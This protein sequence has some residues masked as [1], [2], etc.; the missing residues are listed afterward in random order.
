MSDLDS[1]LVVISGPS[2]TGKD[3]ITQKLLERDGCF[4]LSVSATTRAPRANEQNGVDY[5]FLSEDD[6]KQKIADGE[7][8]EFARYGKN[9][10]G[11]LKQDIVNRIENGK[12]VILVIDVQGEAN[13]KRMFPGSLAIFVSPPSFEVLEKRLRSRNTDSEESILLRLETAKDEM[14]KKDD[15]DFA[16]VNDVLEQAVEDAY[17]IIKDHTKG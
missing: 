10:Y 6:F 7:F 2:G 14:K 5:Y 17:E 9:Y 3:T 13:I 12:T 11:T 8:I 1:K 15:Y 16:I 4:E